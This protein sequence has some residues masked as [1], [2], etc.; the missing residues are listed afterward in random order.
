MTIKNTND[1]KRYFGCKVVINQKNSFVTDLT[2]FGKYLQDTK[3]NL[4]SLSQIIY[5]FYLFLMFSFQIFSLL[6][7]IWNIGIYINCSRISNT[8]F[9]FYFLFYSNNHV[10]RWYMTSYEMCKYNFRVL[11]I[12][13]K[14]IRVHLKTFQIISY[15]HNVQWR[16]SGF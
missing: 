8:I 10:Y 15:N 2:P 13:Q 14:V 4:I 16:S 1:S 12:G 9:I 11:K 6:L 3:L 7:Q 5:L